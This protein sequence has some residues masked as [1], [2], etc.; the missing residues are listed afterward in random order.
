MASIIPHQYIPSYEF[1]ALFS[2]RLL[3]PTFYILDQGVN[4]LSF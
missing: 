1:L 4:T 3:T 2:R